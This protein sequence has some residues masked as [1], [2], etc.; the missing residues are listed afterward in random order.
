MEG[1][2]CSEIS[3]TQKVKNQVAMLG[4][5]STANTLDVHGWQRV[6]Y[7]NPSKRPK[8]VFDYAVQILKDSN[9]KYNFR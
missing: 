4:G 1:S 9:L 3:I 7:D 2:V 8:K 6:I 5:Y